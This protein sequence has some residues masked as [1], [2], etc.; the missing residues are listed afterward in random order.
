MERLEER[1]Q[2]MGPLRLLA[3]EDDEEAEPQPPAPRFPELKLAVEAAISI[4]NPILTLTLSLTL[5]LALSLTLSLALTLA[6]TRR[7]SAST[8][9]PCCPSSIGVRRPTQRGCWAAA[10]GAP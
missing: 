7:R 3:A 6:L 2:C 8:A 4:T 1:R 9:A 5:G 10:C